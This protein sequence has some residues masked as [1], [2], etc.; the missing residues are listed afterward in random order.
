MHKL[1]YTHQHDAA[2]L[3]KDELSR[4]GIH[5]IKTVSDE[6]SLAESETDIF[7]ARCA[8]H[9]SPPIFV[10]H[11][12]PVSV[13]IA[14][15]GV[16]AEAYEKTLALLQSIYIGNKTVGIQAR[17]VADVSAKPRGALLDAIHKAARDAGVARANGTPDY[18]L[19]VI[20][21]DGEVMLGFS[22]A[23]LN[24][25][26]F[27]GGNRSFRRSDELI[28]RSEFKLLEAFEVFGIT[29]SGGGALD[30]GGAPGGW[31]RI[32]LGLGYDVVAVDPA[33]LDERMSNVAG[34]THFR[35]T[36]QQYLAKIGNAGASGVLFDFLANDMKMESSLSS[37]LVCQFAPY[38][39]LNAAVVLT[40]KL[41]PG[42]YLKQIYN[43]RKILETR[44]DI[45]GI[46]QLF[47]N[48]N[49]VTVCLKIKGM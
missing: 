42:K 48:R 21:T 49:E 11:I 14:W 29:P 34:V 8:I 17:S 40:L 13:S 41:L 10:R 6:T 24:L 7:A 2:R 38:M 28:S 35:A 1:I 26:T 37:R 45:V 18:A 39:K 30:L 25:S 36:A 19:S 31:S 22:P 20:M 43:A 46:K 5:T 27:A 44:Y 32:L 16:E 3:A 47:H 12:C 33:E 15:D 23:A 4:F 9:V